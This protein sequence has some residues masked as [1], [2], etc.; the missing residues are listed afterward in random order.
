MR[1]T[2]KTAAVEL[3]ADVS[4]EF[5]PTRRRPATHFVAV[6]QRSS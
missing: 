1:P 3:F 2:H 5:V 4:C 6:T